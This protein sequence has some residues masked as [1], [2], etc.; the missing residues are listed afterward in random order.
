MVV[1]NLE[2]EVHV[3]PMLCAPPQR[4]R[5]DIVS[6]DWTGYADLPM[7][8]QDLVIRCF[9]IYRVAKSACSRI[10][11]VSRHLLGRAQQGLRIELSM[12]RYEDTAVLA[13]NLVAA[14]HSTG[15]RHQ[16]HRGA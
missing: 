11:S 15:R 8:S 1:K 7:T 6:E 2:D 5:S 12:R 10:G 4:H 14:A 3:L 13:S 16:P 9:P